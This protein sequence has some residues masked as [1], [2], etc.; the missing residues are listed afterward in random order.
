MVGGVGVGVLVGINLR[1]C[2]G[3]VCGRRFLEIGVIHAV[4][5]AYGHVIFLA[6]NLADGERSR[7]R[8]TTVVGT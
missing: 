6:A 4:P 3:D 1:G 7:A 2:G 8:Q 5:I